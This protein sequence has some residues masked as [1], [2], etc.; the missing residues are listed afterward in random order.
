MDALPRNK[1]SGETRG[2]VDRS[3][4]QITFYGTLAGVGKNA[5]NPRQLKLPI[6]GVKYWIV[7]GKA[8]S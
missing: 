6:S 4:R 2:F 3:W 7:P 5:I 1:C 8:D